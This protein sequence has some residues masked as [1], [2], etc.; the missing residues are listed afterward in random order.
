MLQTWHKEP[1]KFC[2]SSGVQ[3]NNEGLKVECPPC[4]GTGQR[5]VSNYDNL[6]PGTYCSVIGDDTTIS[7]GND[8]Q[9]TYIN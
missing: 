8:L 3:V 9:L 5:N 1:C 2:G 7:I 4:D 6:P